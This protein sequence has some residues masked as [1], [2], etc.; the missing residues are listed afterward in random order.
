MRSSLDPK[1]PTDAGAVI[2]GKVKLEAMIMR[3]EPLECVEFSYDW[4]DFSRI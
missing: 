4:L 3:E 1:T 2:V